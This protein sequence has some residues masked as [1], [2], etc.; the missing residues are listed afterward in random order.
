LTT[1][2]SQVSEKRVLGSKL[3]TRIGMV[4]GTLELRRG[5]SAAFA[6][7]MIIP[8]FRKMRGHA[9]YADSSLL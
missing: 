8:F 2:V 4:I 7:C 6:V 9:L 1:N 3:V 5:V